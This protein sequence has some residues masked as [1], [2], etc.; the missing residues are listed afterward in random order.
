MALI[1][2]YD[3]RLLLSETTVGAGAQ[4]LLLAFLGTAIGLG[5]A[6]WLTGLAFGLA[7]W[8]VLNRALLRTRT[9]TFG[10]ANRVTLGRAILVGAVTALVA[11][12]FQSSPPVSLFVGLTAVALILD[13]VDGKVARRTGTS[14]ALGARFDMEVDAFLILVL[15]VYVSMSLGPWVLLIGVMR[16]AFVAAAKALPWLN[17]SL[18][19]SMARKTVAA[20][21]GVFLLVAA[22]GLLPYAAGFALVALALGSLIWSF[23][24]DI[25]WLYRTREERTAT[26]SVPEPMALAQPVTVAVTVETAAGSREAELVRS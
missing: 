22:S 12:S 2:T 17:G 10:P 21:Q 20:V 3:G 19:H 4:V 9:R 18:P 7:T 8:A 5:P 16:Y 23:G 24:R 1:N 25:G 6:G 26:G 14:T 11:D 13:G 15:S